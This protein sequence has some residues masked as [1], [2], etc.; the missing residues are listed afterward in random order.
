MRSAKPSVARPAQ[1]GAEGAEGAEGAVPV[2]RKAKNGRS[3]RPPE[4]PSIAPRAPS[5]SPSMMPREPTG[6]TSPSARK[7]SKTSPYASPS[8]QPSS[9]SPMDAAAASGANPPPFQLPDSLQSLD[10][11]TLSAGKVPVHAPV[12]AAPPP[13]DQSSLISSTSSI[14]PEEAYSNDEKHLNNFLKLHPML[15]VSST[16]PHHSA[17]LSATQRRALARLHALTRARVQSCALTAGG[18]IATHASDACRH[19]REGDS[20]ERGAADRAEKP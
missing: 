16:T 1:D 13:R 17:P 10:G 12:P 11:A 8:M 5:V 9:G 15:S 19:V 3:A 2:A 6:G 18:Y 20:P 4:S 7:A 14:G